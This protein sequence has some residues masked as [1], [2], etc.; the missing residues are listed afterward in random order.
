[1]SFYSQQNSKTGVL[2]F[3][4]VA[5]VEPGALWCSCGGGQ[6]PGS[7][8]HD[9]RSPWDALGEIVGPSGSISERCKDKGANECY[10]LPFPSAQVQ[11]HLLTWTQAI[12][13]ALLQTPCSWTM[14]G[15]PF[16]VKPASVQR[17]PLSKDQFRSLK[18]E[19]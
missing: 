12:C 4:A 1:M 11:R 2:E 14:L 7:G 15:P 8:Q 5:G 10:F 6:K 3:C 13:C 18:F 16:W 9:L 17:D 19:F